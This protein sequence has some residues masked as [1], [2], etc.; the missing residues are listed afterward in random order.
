M[1]NLNHR[2]LALLVDRWEKGLQKL[3]LCC[4]TM[5][6]KTMECAN[7]IFPTFTQKD[8]SFRGVPL[9]FPKAHKRLLNTK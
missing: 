9:V 2:P 1:P 7:L 8:M 4:Q 5:F 6:S 3:P